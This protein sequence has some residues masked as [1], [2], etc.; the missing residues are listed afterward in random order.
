M[1]RAKGVLF[2][3]ALFTASHYAPLSQDD[4]FITLVFLFRLIQI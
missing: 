4:T 3:L 2:L 1:T